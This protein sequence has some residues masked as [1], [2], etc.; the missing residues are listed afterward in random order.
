VN[1]HISH[2]APLD[3]P[4]IERR[5]QSSQTS[6][7]RKGTEYAR[8]YEETQA[9]ARQARGNQSFPAGSNR[10]SPVQRGISSGPHRRSPTHHTPGKEGV[11]MISNEA[12][13]HLVNR[14]R[15]PKSIVEFFR[16]SPLVGVELNLERDKDEGRDVEL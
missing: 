16:E 8:E 7:C 12:Y 4:E 9:L 3:K 6:Q 15:Q 14:S 10:Q 2:S 1:S 11:V 13:N 5:Y